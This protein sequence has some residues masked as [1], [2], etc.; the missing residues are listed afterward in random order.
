M[1]NL[2]ILYGQ[3][4][5]KYRSAR[6]PLPGCGEWDIIT[7]LREQRCREGAMKKIDALAETF[8]GSW[9]RFVHDFVGIVVL[10]VEDVA[11]SKQ[12]SGQAPGPYEAR[13]IPLVEKIAE[14]IHEDQGSLLQ[15]VHAELNEDPASWPVL[16]YLVREF[17][18]FHEL[19]SLSRGND[20]D[21]AIE[22]GRTIRG[23]FEEVVAMPGKV[24]KSLKVLDGV[25][26]LL[27]RAA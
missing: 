19:T 11:R 25:L 9:G 18:F 7:V 24:R 15:A 20:V 17:E 12:A 10:K 6:T 4:Y 23:S 13:L 8:A 16:S 27:K 26:E 5:A 21:E 2:R 22:A 1:K 3:M 14:D